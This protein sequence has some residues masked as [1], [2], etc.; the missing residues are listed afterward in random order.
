M[1]DFEIRQCKGTYPCKVNGRTVRITVTYDGEPRYA[2]IDVLRTV[3]FFRND[4]IYYRY[5]HG[6]YNGENTVVEKMTIATFDRKGG[7]S[8]RQC[9]CMNEAAVRMMLDDL[10]ID[11]S[12][13]CLFCE[14]IFP[15]GR[16]YAEF[17]MRSRNAQAHST[18]EATPMNEPVAIASVKG[19][20]DVD[21]LLD[22]LVLTCMMLKKTLS[23]QVS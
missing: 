22:D 12:F 20:D 5:G 10:D 2:A 21:K 18:K 15:V 14:D 16:S 13:V 8:A 19:Y 6:A 17:V 11:Q 3:G 1:K 7:V 4:V 23:K 9:Y